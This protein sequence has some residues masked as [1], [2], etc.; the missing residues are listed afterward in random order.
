VTI[1]SKKLKKYCV[2]IAGV[3]GLGSNCAVSLAR[4]GIGKIVI[5]DYDIV[6][7]SD[8]NRQH[9]FLDQIGEK[10]VLAL[11]KN[12]SKIN[13]DVEIYAY[14]LK[15]NSDKIIKIFKDCDVIVEAVDLA[16]TKQMVIETILSQMPDKYIVSGLGIAGYGK[17][18]EIK[19]RKIDK[20]YICGDEKTEISEINPPLAPKVGIVANMQANQVIEIVL[21]ILNK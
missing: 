9:Y 10:K 4:I 3:G 17:N 19:T 15:L 6:S 18:I 7:K 11:K 5:A 21:D 20:L 1:L 2:G 12:I 16:E 14:D 13:P 8:L